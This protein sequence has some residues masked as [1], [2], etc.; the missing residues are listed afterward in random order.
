MN[1]SKAVAFFGIIVT[2]G[3]ITASHLWE[4][5]SKI[6]QAIRSF[7]EGKKKSVNTKIG[8]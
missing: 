8:R 6:A 7:F 3:A 5:R 2:I 4:S 1:F